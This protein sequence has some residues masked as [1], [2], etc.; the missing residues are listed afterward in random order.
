VRVHPLIRP[1]SSDLI[2]LYSRQRTAGGPL[3]SDTSVGVGYA[4]LDELESI[5]L[6]V[7]R[8]LNSENVKASHPEI[9]EDIKVMGVRLGER[10]TLTI[11]CAL[12]ARHIANM[13]EYLARKAGIAEIA[14]ET[15]RRIST[16][17]LEVK[18]NTSDGESPDSI[19]LTV[20]GTSAEAGDDGQVGRGNRVNGLITPYRPMNMEA[21]AGKNPVTHVGKLYNVTANG[22]AQAVVAEVMEVRD[23]CCWLVSQIGRPIGDAQVVEVKVGLKDGAGLGDVEARVRE[24]AASHLARITELWREMITGSHPVW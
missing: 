13:S 7:E 3:A 21:P 16:A 20:T 23:A 5:V 6:G 2:D 22:I 24:I 1:A 19:Y 17:P 18:V 12:V 4:P 8:H 11:A 10:I 14:Y 9:G 15:A